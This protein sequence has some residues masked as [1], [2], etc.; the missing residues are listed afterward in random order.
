MGPDRY[1]DKSARSAESSGLLG[2][3]GGKKGETIVDITETASWNSTD[4]S[5][6]VD[7]R[8]ATRVGM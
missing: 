7:A 1:S 5:D 6:V 2:S 4:Y 8:V 3:S